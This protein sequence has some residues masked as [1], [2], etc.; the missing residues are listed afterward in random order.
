MFYN[1]LSVILTNTSV[2]QPIRRKDLFILRYLDF[3]N[4]T[5]QQQQNLFQEELQ[6][7]YTRGRIIINGKWPQ[8]S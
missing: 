3:Y 4:T 2:D 8:E 7:Y 6:G 1:Q 5:K